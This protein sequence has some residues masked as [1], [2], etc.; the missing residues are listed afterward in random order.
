METR[1]IIEPSRAAYLS[2]I[3]HVT[4]PDGSR[5]MCLDYRRVNQH[6]PTDINPLPRLEELV[7]TAVG[8]KYYATL[9]LKDAYFH[10]MLEEGSR[11]VTTFSDGVSL[12]WFKRLPFGISCSP[13]IFSRHMAQVLSPLIKQ[14]S[15]KNH[16]DDVILFATDFETL[17]KRLDTLFEH[18]SRSGIKLNLSKCSFG[19]REVKFWGHIVSEAGCRPDPTNVKA[20]TDMKTPTTV[21]G[22]P[23]FLGMCGFYR[24][25]MPK[26]A[27][28]AA[29]LT[30]LTRKNVEFQW[31]E[32]C[33]EAFE[34]LKERL[35]VAPVLIRADINRPF[36]SDHRCQ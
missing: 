28:V 12:Y 34:R 10:V 11:D 32:N 3:V 26:F 27:K 8:H 36:C 20:V 30:N 23:R 2:P 29:P 9:D 14:G 7:E 33:Q 16:L 4:K 17:L 5:R 31:T 1:D 15:V 35:T 19:Q 13:A 24:K 25:H 22:V 18:L 6:L 21:K